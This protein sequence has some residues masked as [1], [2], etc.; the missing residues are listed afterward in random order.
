MIDHNEY[1]SAADIAMYDAMEE[2]FERL[3]ALE[4]FEA[5]AMDGEEVGPMDLMDMMDMFAP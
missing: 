5:L 2:E 4:R 1:M 3:E